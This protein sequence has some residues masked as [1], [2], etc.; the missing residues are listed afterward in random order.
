[1][2]IDKL[3]PAT[4]KRVGIHLHGEGNRDTKKFF[5]VATQFIESSI[6]AD[7][8]GEDL[9]R[10]E[11]WLNSDPYSQKRGKLDTYLDLSLAAY[12]ASEKESGVSE[13]HFGVPGHDMENVIHTVTEILRM[14]DSA[15]VNLGNYA[16][17]ELLISGLNENLGRLVEGDDFT[18]EVTGFL[19]ARD[20]IKRLEPSPNQATEEERLIAK[21]VLHCIYDHGGKNSGNP[22][23]D[24]IRQSNRLQEVEPRFLRRSIEYDVAQVDQDI[25]SPI[26]PQRQSSLSYLLAENP[27]IIPTTIDWGEFYLRNLFPFMSE[28]NKDNANIFKQLMEENQ[29]VADDRKANSVVMLAIL[30]GGEDLELFK[31]VFAPELELVKHDR[32][33]WTKR[34]I[35]EQIFREGLKKYH[36]FV[37]TPPEFPGLEGMSNKQQITAIL[38]A[39]SSYLPNDLLEKIYTKYDGLE[40]NEQKRVVDALHHTLSLHYEELDKELEMLAKQI[41]SDNPYVAKVAGFAKNYLDS[42]IRLDHNPK[43]IL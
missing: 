11:K 35:P 36:E 5:G 39:M 1:M 43:K 41:K 30:A 34:R 24:L 31:Q 25:I 4:T 42:K 9:N 10:L 2:E 6:V 16:K 23:T 7:P 17:W 29:K 19:F 20:V 13:A 33:H 26:D 27:E 37:Q 12:S 40:E 14:I 18:H 3:L 38:Q 22:I 15:Q 28:A 32:L 21:R 8:K